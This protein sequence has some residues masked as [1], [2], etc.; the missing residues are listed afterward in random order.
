LPEDPKAKKEKVKLIDSQV[1]VAD[2]MQQFKR[3]PEGG[4][5][6]DSKL[7]AYRLGMKGKIPDTELKEQLLMEAYQVAVT[8][9]QLLQR[10]VK[11]RA[12]DWQNFATEVQ[13]GAVQLAESVKGKD[14]GSGM[15]AV[16]KMTTNCSSCHKAFRT[17]K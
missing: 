4:W 5:G 7:Y 6:I 3:P 1:K 9:D 12:K 14:G 2:L 16:A 11:D 17:N 8:T 10:D 15:E 13:K